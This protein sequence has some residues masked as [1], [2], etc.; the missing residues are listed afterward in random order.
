[1]CPVKKEKRG[2]ITKYK[3]AKIN[4]KLISIKLPQSL[5]DK[6]KA[7]NLNISLIL[8]DALRSILDIEEMESTNQKSK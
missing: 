6:A 3:K 5:Y 4:N 1:M 2:L 7:A 8:K